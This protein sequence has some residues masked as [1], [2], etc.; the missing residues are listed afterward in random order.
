M[1]NVW[2]SSEVFG[3]IDCLQRSKATREASSTD[4]EVLCRRSSQCQVETS[5][6]NVHI[7]H[8]VL[9][10]LDIIKHRLH[11]WL[12]PCLPVQSELGTPIIQ[13]HKDW[14][15]SRVKI[16]WN[17]WEAIM[18]GKH[19]QLAHILHFHTHGVRC[20]TRAANDPLVFTITVKAPPGWKHLLA[21]SHLRH[22]A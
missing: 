18:F 19:Q 6:L 22:Y 9:S 3:S 7:V 1:F 12:K 5:C 8:V 4:S 17:V 10:I 15:V 2:Q 21:L 14:I 13:S 20:R 11:V 16:N